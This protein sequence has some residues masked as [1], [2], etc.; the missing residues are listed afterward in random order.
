MWACV[1]IVC[2]MRAYLLSE[3]MRAVCVYC[4]CVNLHFQFSCPVTMMSTY[5]SLAVLMYD[6][7]GGN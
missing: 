3:C 4:T 6:M 1:L 7:A 5:I 2:A